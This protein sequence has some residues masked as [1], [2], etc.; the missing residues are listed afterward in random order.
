VVV[1]DE[2]QDILALGD[3][4]KVLAVMR[5][6]IQFLQTVPFVFCGSIRG[7]MN[8]IFTDHDSPF[9]KSALPIEVG[10]IDHAAFSRFIARKFGQAKIAVAPETIDRLLH[11][12]REN[13]GDTQQLCSAICEVARPKD[14]VSDG[15]IALAMQQIYA[16]ERKGYEACLARITAT[17]LRCLTAVARLGGRNTLSREFLTST[18][19]RQPSTVRKSLSRLEDLKI[20]FKTGNEYR[21]VNPFFAQWLVWM[22]Y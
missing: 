9:F 12:T 14:V 7:K 13:P 20:L 3:S 22:N 16:E 21:Y 17:Q 11:L 1:I 8:S 19:I 18:G 15:T 6:K 5:G 2:F 10:P 4:R